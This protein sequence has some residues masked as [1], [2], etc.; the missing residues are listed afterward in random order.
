MQTLERDARAIFAPEINALNA[1]ISLLEA[2][3]DIELKARIAALKMEL[4]YARENYQCRLADERLKRLQEIRKLTR[5][6]EEALKRA[7]AEAFLAK[8]EA[9]INQRKERGAKDDR[10]RRRRE[11]SAT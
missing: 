10:D 1:R 8:Q 6:Y 11:A 7:R 3:A 2:D 5:R 4:A 9:T